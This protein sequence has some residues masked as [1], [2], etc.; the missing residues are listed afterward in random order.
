MRLALGILAHLHQLEHLSHTRVDR[1]FGHLVLLETKGDVVGHTH[2]REQRIG[3]EHHVDR[4]LIGRQVGN[5]LTV[6]VDPPLGRPLETGQH[7]QQGGFT[8][9]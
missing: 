3:L 1:V 8:R 2:V 5:V 9:T 6:E 7:A 4:P